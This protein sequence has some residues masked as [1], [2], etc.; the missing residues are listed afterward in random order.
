MEKDLKIDDSLNEDVLLSKLFYEK[1]KK[2]S[3]YIDFSQKYNEV[4]QTTERLKG[5]FKNYKNNNGKSKDGF[6]F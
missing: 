5:D 6:T 4:K 1:R 2:M 3:M